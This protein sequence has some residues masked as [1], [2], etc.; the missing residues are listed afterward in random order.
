MG[1]TS[2][3]ILKAYLLYLKKLSQK[4]SEIHK[5]RKLFPKLILFYFLAPTHTGQKNKHINPVSDQIYAFL[6]YSGQDVD[7]FSAEHSRSLRKP[8][9]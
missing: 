9:T 2:T 1:L 7:L 4:I 8:A 5:V 3:K 6:P